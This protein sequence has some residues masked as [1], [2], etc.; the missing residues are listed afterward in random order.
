[1]DEKIFR[2][3]LDYTD[4]LGRRGILDHSLNDAIADGKSVEEHMIDVL[5]AAGRLPAGWDQA[6]DAPA[7][8]SA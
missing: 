1:M 5:R 8:Q 3:Y 6:T 7:R 2:A 4:E